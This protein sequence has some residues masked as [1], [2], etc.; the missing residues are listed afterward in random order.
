MG[1]AFVDSLLTVMR[2]ELVGTYA[3]F[4]G[5]AAGK[6]FTANRVVSLFLD[7]LNLWIFMDETGTSCPDRRGRSHVTVWMNDD[8]RGWG[9]F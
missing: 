7:N 4:W 8:L 3:V 1:E 2:L 6:R 5:R 9:Q